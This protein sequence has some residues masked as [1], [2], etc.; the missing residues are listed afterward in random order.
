MFEYFI[1]AQA[2]LA[3]KFQ[4]GPARIPE[5]TPVVRPRKATTEEPVLEG[6][7]ED[8]SGIELEPIEVN[9]KRLKDYQEQSLTINNSTIYSDSQLKHSIETCRLDAEGKDALAWAALCL[10]IKYQKDGYIN[11]RVYID[12]E[13]S[14]P[15]VEVVEG[16][17]TELR[18][19]GE[20]EK[21]NRKVEKKLA[22]L[23]NQILN[24]NEVQRA[25]KIT[26]QLP[27][28]QQIRGRL[29]RIGSDAR[30][31]SLIV[32]AISEGSNLQGQIGYDN[33]GK[34]SAG[35]NR[36]RLIISSNSLLQYDDTWLFY[37]DHSFTGIPE[38]GSSTYSTSYVTPIG[39]DTTATL[40]VGFSKTQPIEFSG[41]AKEFR[42]NQFQITGLTN[43][44]LIDSY[45]RSLGVYGQV[46]YNRSNLYLNGKELPD[47]VPEI[48]RKP[49]N[50]YIKIGLDASKIN[51]Q[52]IHSGK[53]FFTQA[54][55]AFIPEQQQKSLD[56]SDIK[57][58]QSKAI[59]MSLG[60][61][62]VFNNGIRGRTTLTAQKAF[63]PLIGSM[64]FQV[65]ADSGLIGLPGSIASGDSG[66]QLNADGF[67]PLTQIKGWK[68]G[69][70]PFAGFASLSTETTLGELSNTVGAAGAML[71]ITYPARQLSFDIG[72]A[73]QYSDRK[74]VK[75]SWKTWSLGHGLLM[76]FQLS[77]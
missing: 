23:K 36:S 17:I 73:H 66:I 5:Q 47:I 13:A 29:G 15:Q 12:R 31:A 33:Y 38:L 25:L 69:L 46:S 24:A 64:R 54:L 52:S 77:I 21:L 70:K 49:Q 2:G 50:G 11:T 61:Y 72:W 58:Y 63:A 65:G 40:S 56:L 19:S 67:V 16:K 27:G 37:T 34:I 30:D 48:L 10:T 59:G 20:N 51:R 45:D 22:S 55:G 43:T 9:S 28:V 74:S 53:I 76:S 18:V 62:F 75:Q 1:L 41:I 14:T 39:R 3:P 26:Q 7:N 6:E 35:E 71:N 57:P 8:K 68:F 44:K 60:N 32:S 42:T 4:S